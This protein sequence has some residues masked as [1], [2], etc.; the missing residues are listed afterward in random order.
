[1]LQ[2]W[3]QMIFLLVQVTMKKVKKDIEIKQ[4]PKKV[5][6]KAIKMIK[7]MIRKMMPQDL[8]LQEI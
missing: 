4:E 7:L 6:F 1:M 3:V 8:D 2:N 5:M